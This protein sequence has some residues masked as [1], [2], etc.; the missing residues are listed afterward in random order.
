MGKPHWNHEEAIVESLRADPAFAAE[1]LNAVLEDGD[2]AELT[3][4]LRRLAS[5]FGGV[6]HLAEEAE[7]NATRA[8][9][10]N[11]AVHGARGGG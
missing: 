3:L 7:L 11:R 5:A 6:S 1:Y 10:I 2:Q 4:A 9:F 8:H